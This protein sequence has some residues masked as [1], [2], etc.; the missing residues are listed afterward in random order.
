M[1]QRF[2]NDL[3]MTMTRVHSNRIFL[4]KSIFISHVVYRNE[5]M[6][7]LVVN[8]EVIAVLLVMPDPLLVIRVF[9]LSVVVF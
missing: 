2:N 9:G 8:V 6:N 3:S 1:V 7:N 4:S 5:N